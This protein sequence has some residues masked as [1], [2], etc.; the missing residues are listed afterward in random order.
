M[1]VSI[2]VFHFLTC[3]SLVAFLFPLLAWAECVLKDGSPYN[4]CT[5]ITPREV[6]FCGAGRLG[7]KLRVCH[8]QPGKR[9][10]C[11]QAGNPNHES[12]RPNVKPGDRAFGKWYLK[13]RRWAYCKSIYIRPASET[14]CVINIWAKGCPFIYSGQ[15]KYDYSGKDTYTSRLYRKKIFY[16]SALGVSSNF[17]MHYD[18]DPT[19]GDNQNNKDYTNDISNIWVDER[20]RENYELV[21]ETSCA[22]DSSNGFCEGRLTPDQFFDFSGTTPIVKSSVVATLRAEPY[23]I[24]QHS[25]PDVILSALRQ[26]AP[27]S[28]YDVK[29]DSMPN[30]TEEQKNVRAACCT[31]REKFWKDFCSYHRV[32]VTRVNDPARCNP[33]KPGCYYYDFVSTIKEASETSLKATYIDP[34]D[35]SE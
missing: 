13:G 27:I 35:P 30:N 9:G 21:H 4:N 33:P 18:G 14:Q 17:E 24:H 6:Y 15:K 11:C 34:L 3:G 10:Y 25:Q 20:G 32:G 12:C 2:R 7:K 5:T 16:A 31:G 8:N 1:P 23:F 19:D 26:G 29:C 28:F 22:R